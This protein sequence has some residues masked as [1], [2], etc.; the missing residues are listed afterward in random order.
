MNNFVIFT[1]SGADLSAEM[2]KSFDVQVIPMTLIING[3]EYLNYPDEREISNKEFYEMIRKGIMGKTAAINTETAIEAFE[4]F[5]KEGRDLL[6]LG[7]SGGL[8]S[9]I[10]AM[11]AAAEQLSKK[12][13]ERKVYAVDTLCASLGQGMLV[14]LCCQQRNEGKSIDEVRDFA[15]NTKLH[16]SHWFTVDDLNHLKKGGR[17]SAATALLGTMLHIKPVLHVD[18][19][20]HLISMEKARG[21]K[22][23]IRRIAEKVLETALPGIEDQQLFICHGDCL[24]EAKVLGAEVKKLINLKKE[25]FYNC[26]GPVIGSHSGTGTLAVFFLATER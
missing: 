5:L 26:I 24:E 18:N 19:E 15:E 6:Y 11:K 20:G 12:Y 9:T 17:L 14:Y 13:P 7:F 1:D 16:L 8:S 2:V 4:P 25:I 3:R 23:A 21:R 10:V 22:A